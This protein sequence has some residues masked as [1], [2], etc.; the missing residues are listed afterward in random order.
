MRLFRF[1]LILSLA[2][3]A[4]VLAQRGR[5]GQSRGNGRGGTR[6]EPRPELRTKDLENL[7]PARIAI[8]RQKDLALTTDETARLDSAAKAYDLQ[9]KDFGKGIDTLQNIMVNA[10]RSLMGNPKGLAPHVS[11]DPPKSPKDS[12]GRARNDS[13]DQAKADRDQERYMAAHDALS[14]TLLRIR[15]AYDDKLSTVNA[16]LTEDQR[17]KIGPWFESASDELTA[18]LHAANAGIGA[19]R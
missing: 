11:R 15:A 18:R 6:P 17:R 19:G 2:L 13:T 16:L 9:A 5:G 8:D 10:V 4:L 3:P 14:S 12:I 1:T 7:N